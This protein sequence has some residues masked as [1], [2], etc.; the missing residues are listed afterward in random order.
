M[1][2][3]SPEVLHLLSL[4]EYGHLPPDLAS[5]SSRF[6]ELAH[7]MVDQRPETDSRD[8]PYELIA[9]LRKLAE[10]KDC[11]VRQTVADINELIGEP[12]PWLA[13][14]A[15]IDRHEMEEEGL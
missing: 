6:A 15:K 11:M 9:G 14:D 2:R 13:T 8:E 10:A 12:Q 7:E 4:F 5:V 3:Q 1:R